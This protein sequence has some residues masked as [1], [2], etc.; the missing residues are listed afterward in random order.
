[1]LSD[2]GS[3]KLSEAVEK[4]NRKCKS[5]T[6]AEL[7]AE[8][9]ARDDTPKPTRISE[10]LIIKRNRLDEETENQIQVPSQNQ[11]TP[12]KPKASK[13]FRGIFSIQIFASSACVLQINE[14]PFPLCGPC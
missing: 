2:G 10:R 5:K 12:K 3:E 1:M 11:I 6:V 7:P 9:K 4:D 8:T 14:S 13:L